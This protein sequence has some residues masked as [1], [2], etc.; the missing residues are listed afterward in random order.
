M[1]SYQQ[2]NNSYACQNSYTQNKLLKGELGFQGFIMSDWQAQHV[3]VGAALA[4]LDMSMPG[5]TTFGTGRSYW[6]ANMTIA[7]ANGTLPEWRLDDMAVRIMAAYYR[8]GRDRVARPSNFNSWTR[9]ELG[10]QHAM[11]SERFGVVNERVNVRGQH[12]LIAR[13]VASASVVLLKNEGVLP[14]TGHE[15]FTGVIGE[16]AG[17]NPKGPNGC[18]DRGCTEGTLAMGWG[19]GTADFPYLVTPAE[20]I[21]REVLSVG[22]GNVAAVFDNN[23]TTEIKLVASQA[24][25]AL[26][27]VNAGAGEGYISV[28]GNSD[29]LNLTV[30]GEGDRLIRNVT[31]YCNNTIVVMH[32]GGPVLVNEW[33]DNPN[34]TAILWAGLP[35]QESGNALTDVLYGRVNPGGKS[36]F[37]WGTTREDYGAPILW[38]ANRGT[39]APQI[40][41]EEGIFI[42]Y[43]AFDRNNIE[44]E[45]EFGFGLSYTTFSYADLVVERVEAEPYVPTTGRSEPAPR[46]GHSSHDLAQYQ[47]P[48]G[49]E[50]VPLYIYPWV[51]STNAKESS[52]DRN[53]GMN[54]SAYLPPGATHGGPRELLG[55][56]GGPGGNPRLFDVLYRVSATVTNT[57]SVA[58]DE[59]PQLV[60]LITPSVSFWFCPC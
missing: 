1:C 40:D 14:L 45:Y 18:P 12:H 56:G 17:P 53:Y 51:N 48:E 13:E 33:K 52:G 27:F 10:F 30:W 5:D 8:V 15:T 59:V 7:V 34:V 32:S 26:V 49:W 41:F 11:V 6:G 23:A 16:D 28:D 24:T 19:S 44:P 29:R 50:R 43:R 47:F 57:G 20:A 39:Q 21:Q 58:G 36:P 4:G 54:S 37:T 46:L 42:D 55:A 60:S 9:D 2:I 25:V 31:S 22:N 35:G 38:E 3:G